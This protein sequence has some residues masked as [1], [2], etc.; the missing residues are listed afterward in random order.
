MK[1]EHVVSFTM[2]ELIQNLHEKVDKLDDKI[3]GQNEKFASRQFVMW[4]AGVL[5]TL[6]G[7][8]IKIIL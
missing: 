5:L 7:I 6:V 3:S 8:T 2:K 1:K 4:V